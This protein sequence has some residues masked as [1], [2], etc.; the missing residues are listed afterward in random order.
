MVLRKGLEDRKPVG[1]R[2]AAASRRRRRSPA[3]RAPDSSRRPS[4]RRPRASA[5]T[6]TAPAPKR[7]PSGRAGSRYVAT[8]PSI[9]PLA[10]RPAVS[11]IGPARLPRA[12]C[13][14]CGS[15]R[16]ASADR[17]SGRG[18][19]EVTA[20]MSWSIMGSD[21]G[22]MESEWDNGFAGLVDRRVRSWSTRVSTGMPDAVALGSRC[23][24]PAPFQAPRGAARDVELCERDRIG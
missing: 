19:S 17:L 18:P 6:G 5:T 15:R 9:A 20:G 13:G 21:G 14:A 23:E 7:G 1:D 10:R 22:S 8:K 16:N 4:R 12:R 11:G 24:P 2:L 3:G